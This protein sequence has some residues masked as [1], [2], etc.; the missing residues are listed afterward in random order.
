MQLV[1]CF[2][3]G[4]DACLP[5]LIRPVEVITPEELCEKDSDSVEVQVV[6]TASNSC[7]DEFLLFFRDMFGSFRVNFGSVQTAPS[8]SQKKCRHFEIITD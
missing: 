8:T 4:G 5:A 2:W 1:N 3:E 7:F 6:H